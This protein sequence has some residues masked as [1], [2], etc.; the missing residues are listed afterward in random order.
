[1]TAEKLSEL[2]ILL[3]LVVGRWMPSK[4]YD[5]AAISKRANDLLEEFLQPYKVNQVD[6]SATKVD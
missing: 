5:I 1:M 6:E 2:S 3:S 4:E